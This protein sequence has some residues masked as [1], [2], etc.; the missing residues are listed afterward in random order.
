M[1]KRGTLTHRRT[2]RL[3]ALLKIPLPCALGV[4]EAVWHVTAAHAPAGDLGRLPDQDLA[5]ELYWDGDAAAL[6]EALLGSGVLER[7]PEHRLVVHGWSEH[8][9]SALRHKLKRAGAVFWD[10]S[11]PFGRVPSP[12]DADGSPAGDSVTAS[13]HAVTASDADEAC[14]DENLPALPVP[15]PATSA[16][17]QQPANDGSPPGPPASRV[18]TT[19]GAGEGHHVGDRLRD[20]RLVL[21][22]DDVGRVV[23]VGRGDGTAP[24]LTHDAQAAIDRIVEYG[25]KALGH[26]F[27]RA[28]RR[29][30]R[31]RLLGGETEAQIL[32]SYRD[33]VAAL[34][35]LEVAEDPPEPGADDELAQGLR[36]IGEGDRRAS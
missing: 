14:P 29:R 1:A 24:T 3:A 36:L 33:Q 25:S 23:V 13:D 5:D 34:E 6:V 16:S 10:G 30:L 21:E 4:M 15:V 27:D 7:H 35:A 17:N 18:G 19:G 26:R 32:A 8:A 9:D 22:V 28:A 12:T 20:G 2:R 31:E 11:P